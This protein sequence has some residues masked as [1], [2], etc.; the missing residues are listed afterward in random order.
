MGNHCLLV[1][2]EELSS[3][4]FVGG[5]KWI[6]GAEHCTLSSC[7][8][9]LLL[10]LFLGHRGQVALSGWFYMLPAIKKNGVTGGKSKIKVI[11][12]IRGTDK[13]AVALGSTCRVRLMH[14][15]PAFASSD[16]P[17]LDEHL[18]ATP[19]QSS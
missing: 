19:S 8:V 11:H 10:L 12:E 6:Y 14:L 2:P 17:A 5:A 18:K 3:R 9:C 13:W 7:F 1:F 15:A 16:Q 4:V